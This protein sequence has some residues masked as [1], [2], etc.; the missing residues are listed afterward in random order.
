MSAYR[1]RLIREA[2]VLRARLDQTLSELDNLVEDAPD[3]DA[4]L[5]RAVEDIDSPDQVNDEHIAAVEA[6]IAQQA[7][8]AA[9]RTL[10]G[11]HAL[12]RLT[13][14][15][16][17]E[18]PAQP[19]ADEPP[20][21]TP[22]PIVPSRAGFTAVIE[23]SSLTLLTDTGAVPVTEQ[24]RGLVDAIRRGIADALRAVGYTPV[25]IYIDS[26]E[27]GR[28]WFMVG[29]ERQSMDDTEAIQ[30]L[31]LT[32]LR[33]GLIDTREYALPAGGFNFGRDL[34]AGVTAPTLLLTLQG[35]PVALSRR[36]VE[37][38]IHYLL[39]L[40]TSPSER[41]T[42]FLYAGL[43]RAVREWFGEQAEAIIDA[44]RA[45]AEEEAGE[46]HEDGAGEDLTA[47]DKSTPSATALLEIAARLRQLDYTAEVIHMAAGHHLLMVDGTYPMDA[48]DARSLIEA[49][50]QRGETIEIRDFAEHYGRGRGGDDER[51]G[52]S[53]D[54]SQAFE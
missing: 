35:V 8:E 2:L 36:T 50:E 54:F 1:T 14:R 24:G 41:I 22:T 51:F 53:Y 42:D 47:A 20:A 11:L 52:W 18:A 37:D 23:P 10:Q 31:Q 33:G 4:I 39:A 17:T 28:R 7:A 30:L 34:S 21:Q 27:D 6:A 40:H 45:E 46:I 13:F 12:S 44:A 9:A 25:G 29:A 19:P 48:D 15:T 5:V 16:S 26:P 3:L 49:T 43:R 32:R 38:M